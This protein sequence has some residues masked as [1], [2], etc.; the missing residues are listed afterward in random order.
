MELDAD[1]RVFGYPFVGKGEVGYL[2]Q[3]LHVADNG[4]LLALFFCLEVKLKGTY[5]FAIDL[6]QG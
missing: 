4:I 5:Q 3:T 6:C 1:E 2:L